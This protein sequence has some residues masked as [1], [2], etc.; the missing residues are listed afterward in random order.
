VVARKKRVEVKRTEAYIQY[1]EV[2]GHG[3]Y[4]ANMYTGRFWNDFKDVSE[5]ISRRWKNRKYPK[6]E[7]TSDSQKSASAFPV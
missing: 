1:R 4:Q 5:A 7:T 3:K 2:Y 6:P